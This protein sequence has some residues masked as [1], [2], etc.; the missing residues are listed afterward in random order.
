MP[1]PTAYPI[2]EEESGAELGATVDLSKWHDEAVP[3]LPE[4]ALLLL[5]CCFTAAILR[6][7]LAS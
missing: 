5:Y 4:V 7:C 2:V 1:D 3:C 6:Q